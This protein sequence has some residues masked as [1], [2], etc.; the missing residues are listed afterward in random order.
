VACSALDDCWVATGSRSAWHWRGDGFAAGG[1]EVRVLA[2]V[3]DRSGT[4]ALHRE[5]GSKVIEVSRIDSAGEWTKLPKLELTTPGSDPEV[6]FARLSSSGAVWV[7]L[8]YRDGADL[9]SFGVAILD[10]NS[11]KVQIHHAGGLTASGKKLLP[12][13]TGVL[14]GVLRNDVAWFATASGVA[15]LALGQIKLWTQD[16]GLHAAGARAIAV[17]RANT[18]FAATAAG[19]GRFDGARWQFPA[20]L[21][22]EVNDLAVTSG[23]QLWMATTRG[24]A[25]YDG[26]RVRRVDL[27]RGLVEN[28]ILDITVDRYDRIWGRSAGSLIL[29][30]P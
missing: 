21:G 22:F 13:P 28:D 3:R 9:R 4:L 19:V 20:Q 30:S 6:S 17:T 10:A 11:G 15:R 18:V 16:D 1:P 2:V 27:R 8:R 25:A 24:I 5:V 12:I 26:A 14:D 23:D 7:G 29:I